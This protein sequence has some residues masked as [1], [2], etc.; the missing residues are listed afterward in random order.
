M[1]YQAADKSNDRLNRRAMRHFRRAI[2]ALQVEELHLHGRVM[3]GPARP[4]HASTMPSSMCSGWRHSLITTYAHYPPTARIMHRCF[5][6]CMP[7]HGPNH[8]SVSKH[9][10]CGWMAT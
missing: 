7:R 6:V 10:G 5:Y 4:S 8:A 9:F 1:I 3:S 2:D